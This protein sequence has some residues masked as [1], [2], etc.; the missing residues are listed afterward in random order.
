MFQEVHYL[1][2]CA[3]GPSIQRFSE[4]T[5]RYSNSYSSDL[6]WPL[7]NDS[8]THL[9]SIHYATHCHNTRTLASSSRACARLR[10]L[11]SA[12]AARGACR[13]VTN[14]DINLRR[15]N[16]AKEFANWL[17]FWFYTVMDRWYQHITYLSLQRKRSLLYVLSHIRRIEEEEEEKRYNVLTRLSILVQ[18]LNTVVSF[19]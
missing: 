19:E 16:T 1:P 17:E 18:H 3:N 12:V 9:L 8:T 13:D 14:S 15:R 5:D 11:L 2:P 7:Q 4:S 10:L 6:W